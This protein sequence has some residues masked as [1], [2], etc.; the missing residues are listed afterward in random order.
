MKTVCR[1][2]QLKCGFKIGCDR[3]Q[4]ILEESETRTKTQL[5]SL[6]SA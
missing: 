5:S 2:I 4:I 1:D 3:G 6:L